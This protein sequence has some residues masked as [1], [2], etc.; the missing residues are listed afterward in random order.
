M[1]MWRAI[2]T[3]THPPWYLGEVHVEDVLQPLERRRVVW[4]ARL[5]ACR[6]LRLELAV[7]PNLGVAKEAIRAIRDSHDD[8]FIEGLVDRLGVRG[9]RSEV[10]G[11]LRD[12]GERALE[13]LFEKLVDRATPMAV[14]VHI[15]RT[16]SRFGSEAST[17]YLL[18]ALSK[19]E[20][21]MLRFKVLR[22]LESQAREHAA[23]HT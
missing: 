15:P 11:A 19:V 23:T 17:P 10:R 14:R 1:W 3:A 21:G 18:K 13:V 2:A 9:A 6:P 12:Y 8:W 4:R 22:G 20:S 5:A 16:L 7:D